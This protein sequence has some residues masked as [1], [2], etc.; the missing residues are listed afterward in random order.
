M[1]DY[2]KWMMPRYA[3]ATVNES[4]CF[5][6]EVAKMQS[7]K[8]QVD[9][10]TIIKY[11]KEFL[12]SIEMKDINVLEIDLEKTPIKWGFYTN[13]M[14]DNKLKD[15]RDIVWM[16]F[17]TDRYV[18]VVATGA[19]VNF[20]MDNTSGKIIK[21]LGKQWNDKYVLIF[22]LT[23]IKYNRQLIESG[24]GNY[25]ISKEVPILDYYSHNL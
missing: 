17:T 18:G 25:L 7:N 24:I 13:I 4:D 16:K 21:A 23:N 5:R 12:N 22:P 10:H 20:N 2:Y 11:T 3:N 14:K 1:N 6:I 15:K 9:V 19:D 8:K